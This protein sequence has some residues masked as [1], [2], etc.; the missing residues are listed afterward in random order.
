MLAHTLCVMLAAMPLRLDVY[1][2]ST[3]TQTVALGWATQRGSTVGT[4][5]GVESIADP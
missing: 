1:M 3:A 5:C 4:Y 2:S